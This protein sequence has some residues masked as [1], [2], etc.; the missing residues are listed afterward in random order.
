M[1]S[2]PNMPD[3][4]LNSHREI[5]NWLTTEINTKRLMIYEKYY[6]FLYDCARDA[7]YKCRK[8]NKK[9]IE[10]MLIKHNE[11]KRLLKITVN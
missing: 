4:S 2:L 8:T 6:K 7:R 10:R 3:T 9:I 5:M 11:I 1:F